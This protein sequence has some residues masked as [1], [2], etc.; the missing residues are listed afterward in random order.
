[1]KRACSNCAWLDMN[2]DA[3]NL[4]VESSFGLQFGGDCDV[5]MPM[6]ERDVRGDHV[7]RLH[8]TH[9]ERNAWENIS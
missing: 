7:C 8:Q 1:M 6:R 4:M 5:P 3:Y 9:D 2:T